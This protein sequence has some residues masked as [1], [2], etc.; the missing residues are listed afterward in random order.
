MYVN[1]IWN[2]F[3]LFLVITI[4]NNLCF[5]AFPFQ[6]DWAC[7][8]SNSRKTEHM[9]KNEQSHSFSKWRKDYYTTGGHS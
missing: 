6:R 2:V 4:Q 7:F 5:V 8:C 9:F 3:G 1:G